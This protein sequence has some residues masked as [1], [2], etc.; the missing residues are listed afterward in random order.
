MRNI[1]ACWCGKSV[2]YIM[3][4]LRTLRGNSSTIPS[5][6][7]VLQYSHVGNQP[8]NHTLS[9]RKPPRLST[10]FL[11]ISPLMNTIFTHLPQPLLLLERSKKKG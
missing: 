5:F 4:N 3:D 6:F 8:I 7:P 1:I 2:C 11:C 9:T 10:L